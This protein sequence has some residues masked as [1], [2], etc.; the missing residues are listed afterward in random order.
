MFQTWYLH[1]VLAS[2]ATPMPFIV[3]DI[4]PEIT[5]T[6]TIDENFEFS[7]TAACNSF[8]G[9]LDSNSPYSNWTTS[10]FSTDLDCGV[11]IH[12]SFEAE[13]FNYLQML[14]DYNIE[15]DEEGLVLTMIT[16]LMVLTNPF[17]IL[18]SPYSASLG[19]PAFF[20]FVFGSIVAFSNSTHCDFLAI[21][22]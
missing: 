6:L 21:A 18:L 22:L 3:S 14:N 9:T 2:D 8:N 15:A 10:F 12:N 7:G 5:P 16:F 11:A 17:Q 1:S 19:A 13:Y 4:T 20:S